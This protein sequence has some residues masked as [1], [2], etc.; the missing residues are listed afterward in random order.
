M[1]HPISATS[2]ALAGLLGAGIIVATQAIS[3][4]PLTQHDAGIIATA[5]PSDSMPDETMLLVSRA[6][7]T[8]VMQ[9]IRSDAAVCFKKNSD[10]LTTCLTQGAPVVD[11]VTKRVIGFEMIEEQIELVAKHN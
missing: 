1:K 9:R 7:G 3:A 10:S 6:D 11:P 2:L 8:V 5:A 4:E